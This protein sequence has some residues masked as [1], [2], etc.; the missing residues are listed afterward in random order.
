V[1]R[2]IRSCPVCA[3][4]RLALFQE[5][6]S[7]PLNIC[8]D[9]RHITW[10]RRPDPDELDDYYR[11]TYTGTHNQEALQD[12]A[13][14]YYRSHLEE[15][16]SRAKRKARKT[17]IVDFGCS[18]PTLLEEARDLGFARPIGVEPDAG[19]RDRG[20]SLGI[21]MHAPEAFDQAIDKGAVHIA[22]FSHVL[23]HLPDPL[24]ALSS[25]VRKVAPGGLIHIT[26]PS[27]PVLAPERCDEPLRDCVWPEHLHYFNAI[28]LRVLAERAGLR[29]T[30]LFTHQNADQ[31]VRHFCPALDMAAASER[32]RD[33]ASAGNPAYGRNANYPAYAGENSALYAIAP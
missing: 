4:K 30:T 1:T 10:D 20:A 31:A 9:C 5:T 6:G 16:I 28:S 3:A 33:L 11:S 14:A 18:F 32:M 25:V 21:E 8:A 17:T 29:I 23:E 19:A 15:L 2:P 7:G 26:Q 22:R 12:S 24:A 27:F 13:R